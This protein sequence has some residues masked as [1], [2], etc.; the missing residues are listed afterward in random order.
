MSVEAP[1]T[2]SEAAA[3]QP[4]APVQSAGSRR[5]R[6]L[7]R[8]LRSGLLVLLCQLALLAFLLGLWELATA[9]VALN[10][11]LF[12]SPSAIWGF[13]VQMWKDGSL[14]ND[15]R[16]TG[17]E[18]LLGFVIGNVL[19]TLI[20][21]TLWYSSFVSRVVQPFIV[22]LGSIP[23]I[24]LAPICIIWF[25]TGLA[26]KVAMATL[27]VVV[28]ALVT[29]YKGAMTVDADQI[30][31][32]R[33]LGA[34]KR[35]I[36]RKLII[37]ASLGDIFAGLKLTVGFALIGAIIGEF[38]SSSEG[39]GHAIFKAG[40]LYIVPKVFAA[41]VVTIT[42]ALCLTYIVGKIERLLT[43]WRQ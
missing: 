33:T 8:G 5:V 7:P 13:L 15:T 24:A 3:A 11:F 26:S 14:V 22:A 43:P 28:V 32:M 37:P 2:L 6:W 31:M 4:H 20:G 9:S 30:N 10:A 12:G 42:L 36:F 29:A 39:L 17:M 41:L 18:T 38:M 40:S 21:L 25:G 16:V 19:G 23:I 35:H 27:S 34:S 1:H